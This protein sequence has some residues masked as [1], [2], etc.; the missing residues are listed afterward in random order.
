MDAVEVFQ[1]K[2][3]DDQGFITEAVAWLVPEPVPGSRHRYK[4]RFYF[5]R[6]GER[7]LGYDN[8]RGKGDHRHLGK[9]EFPYDFRD[10]STLIADFERDKDEW[11]NKHRER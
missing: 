4:Y 11:K 6:D 3:T 7:L 2:E 8:E 5:G 10:I 9:R 1:F